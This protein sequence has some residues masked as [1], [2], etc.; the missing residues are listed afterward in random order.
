VVVCAGAGQWEAARSLI[1]TMEKQH[2]KHAVN[3]VALGW[4]CG[5]NFVLYWRF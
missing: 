2:G 4:G 3:Q 5:G 1:A